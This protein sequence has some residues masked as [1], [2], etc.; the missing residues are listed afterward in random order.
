M[1]ITHNIHPPVT[2]NLPA[3]NLRLVQETED[4]RERLEIAEAA[5]QALSEVP[6][7]QEVATLTQEMLVGIAGTARR[8][9]ML[10]AA[11]AAMA[12]CPNLICVGHALI[13]NAPRSAQEGVADKVLTRVE[14]T[15][16]APELKIARTLLE[17]ST[18]RPSEKAG[19]VQNVIGGAGRDTGLIEATTGI[20]SGPFETASH[21][22]HAAQ[23]TL[24]AILPLV[25]AYSREVLE[26]A[27][28]QLRSGAP[29][30][31]AIGVTKELLYAANEEPDRQLTSALFAATQKAKGASKGALLNQ[32][33]ELLRGWS[34]VDGMSSA[35]DLISSAS[36][37]AGHEQVRVQQASLQALASV[38]FR[39]TP[40][41]A[42]AK[43][44]VELARYA[45]PQGGIGETPACEPVLVAVLEAMKGSVADPDAL[46]DAIVR[47]KAVK[48]STELPL[49][50]SSRQAAIA[51]RALQNAR[52]AG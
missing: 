19:I 41:L 40:A 42:V 25:P 47:L 6:R 35:L 11:L 39:E 20:I 26:L 1:L 16:G 34:T 12:A 44:L 43:R 49:G 23:V 7:Y 22:A 33:F 29:T 3:L 8:Q 30:R 10:S 32:S 15:S 36:A 24:D 2:A 17:D 28:E 9:A 45:E 52:T 48:P 13:G 31:S 18:L 50:R 37:V 46:Q 4:P 5:V 27:L 38:S 21:Q 51:A 14:S